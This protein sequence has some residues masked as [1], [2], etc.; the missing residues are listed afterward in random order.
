MG[1]VSDPQ[2]TMR[3]ASPADVGVI[4]DIVHEAF[5][6]RPACDPP[7]AALEETRETIAARLGFSADA[8]GEPATGLIAA[9]DGEDVG[10]LLITFEDDE[11]VPT[12]MLHRVS[13]RPAHRESGVAAAMVRTAAELVTDSGARRLQLMA[14]AEFPTVIDWWRGYG[15]EIVRDVPLGHIL[16]KDLPARFEVPTAAAMQ[17]LG[18][19]VASEL[20]AGDVIVATGEL[21]AGKTTFTQGLAAGL[22]V[23]GA[24]ISPTFVLARIHRSLTDGPDL[25]HVDAYRLGSPAELAD[26]DLDESLASSITLIEWGEGMIK[27]LTDTWLDLV[28][29]RSGDPA[30]ETRVVYLTGIGPRWSG[31]D[32]EA[33]EVTR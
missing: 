29:R 23:G 6:A 18:R 13:V 8:T 5:A 15:F 11:V 19:A 31:I 1:A 21:G 26:L 22:G 2:L 30:D 17:A 10:A 16:A 24:V 4:L 27:G 14:R 32:L 9:L 28:I 7:A 3:L 25:V 20:R 12:A 33:L